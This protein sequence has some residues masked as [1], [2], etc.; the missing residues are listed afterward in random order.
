M[1]FSYLFAFTALFLQQTL[2][3][4]WD[5]PIY[6]HF[7]EFPM[8]I[9]PTKEV[10]FTFTSPATGLPIDYYEVIIK[11][12]TRQQY[13]ELAPTRM[14]GYDGLVPGKYQSIA[15]ERLS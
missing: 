12:L 2:A 5:S 14:V 3:K 1:R 13:P 15:L 8:P 11:P 6:K 10:K 7:Y 9:P 4:D